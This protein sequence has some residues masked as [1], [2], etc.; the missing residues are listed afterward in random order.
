MSHIPFTLCDTMGLEEGLNAGLDVDDFFNILKGHIQD[1]YQ[2]RTLPLK[3]EG[4]HPL[5][6]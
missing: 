4:V 1:R 2:V 6:V 3:L 5:F